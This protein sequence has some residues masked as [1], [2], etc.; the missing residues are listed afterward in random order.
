LVAEVAKTFDSTD[1]N[2]KTKFNLKSLFTIGS[3]SKLISTAFSFL[4]VAILAPLFAGEVRAQT[5]DSRLV[6]AAEANELSL[7]D[8]FID[9]ENANQTQPDGT[10]VLHWAVFHQHQ[11][12][13]VKLIEA[14][15]EVNCQNDYGVSPLSLACELGHGPAA[16]ALVKNGADV[17]AKRTGGETPLMLAARHGD[18][19][20]VKALIAAGANVDATDKKQQTAL[21]WAAA[22]GNLE[23]VNQLI[24]AE[25][26]IDQRTEKSGFTA[27]LFAA[28]QGKD[29]VVRRLLDAGADVN[30]VLT[31]KN[32]SGRNPRKAM[33]AL[34]LA[35]ESGHLELALKLVE[36]GADPNDQRS[37][38]APLHAL[39]WVRKTCLGDNPAGDPAPVGSGEVHSL[40]F[41]RQIIS[42]GADV[43]LRLKNGKGGRA[44]LHTKQA[45]PFLLASQTADVPFMD[46]LLELGADPSLNNV[47][48]CT[49]LIACAGIGAVNVGEEPGTETEVNVAIKLLVGLGQDVNAVDK[50]KETAIHGAAYRNYPATVRL[51][52]TLGAKPK[53]WNHKNKSGWT[54]MDIA[55]GHRPG[56]LKPSPPTQAALQEALDAAPAKDD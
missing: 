41:A 46:L 49:P 50:N 35:V 31:P 2:M 8:W 16:V 25:A 42:M 56:S 19:T 39:T 4:I 43:N 40:E 13:I 24:E 21:M 6:D 54:P 7:A 45:T 15:A 44:R 32:S 53:V 29:D 30:S 36:W 12:A 23:A 10:S 9:K 34:M 26:N 55:F 5:P 11:S 17:E 48:D 20:V 37:G 27:F 3:S 33:S 51:L 28:R 1:D 14:D 52:T 47:D 18:E 38:F 22:A